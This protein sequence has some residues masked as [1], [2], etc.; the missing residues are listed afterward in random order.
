M[1]LGAVLYEDSGRAFLEGSNQPLTP[2]GLI[3]IVARMA[4]AGFQHVE[5]LGESLY[6]EPP[7]LTADSIS[8]LRTLAEERGLTYSVH[9]QSGSGVNV[10]CPVEVV[11]R[12][13]VSST[14]EVI[15]LLRPLNVRHYVLHVVWSEAHA[16]RITLEENLSGKA[17]DRALA[18]IAEQTAKSL[19]EMVQEVDSRALCLENVFIDYDWVYPL[20]IEFDTSICFDG[21]HWH[22]LGHEATEFVER[23]GERVATIH[24]HD[25]KDGAD[26][27][28]LDEPMTIN[29]AGALAGLRDLGYAGPV[30]LEFRGKERALRSLATLKRI[31]AELGVLPPSL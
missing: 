9:L 16:H 7:V 15:R 25:V 5:L 11:R 8:G 26:H 31:F 10:D 14:L 27:Q 12:A 18:R 29:W 20:V 3:G 17:Q 22:L 4:D 13:A 23:Y 1:R 24:C 21:G 28:A 2:Q 30:V 19:Q 6:A